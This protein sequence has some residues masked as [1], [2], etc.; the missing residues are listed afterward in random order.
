MTDVVE[1]LVVKGDVSDINA[2]LDEMEKK[3]TSSFQHG[4]KEAKKS[5][6]SMAASMFKG[7]TAATLL[8]KAVNVTKGEFVDSIK[9]AID[10]ERSYIQQKAAIDAM[11][12]G[13]G[14]Y[15]DV[16]KSQAE[17]MKERTG[18]DDD[19]I[20]SIQ[21]MAITYGKTMSQMEGYTR[22]TIM[23]SNATGGR[24]GLTEAMLALVKTE[25]EGALNR[26]LKGIPSLE[27]LTK[28]QLL[29]GEAIGAINN[30]LK[31]FETSQKQGAIG[32]INEM[33]QAWD[34]L[35]K[36]IG[37]V[38]IHSDMVLGS[39]R[40]VTNEI[41]SIQA[42][43][44]GQF[45]HQVLD[46]GLGGNFMH[47]ITGTQTFR[48]EVGAQRAAAALAEKERIDALNAAALRAEQTTPQS[49]PLAAGMAAT[50]L[51]K[52][53]KERMAAE[54]K[55]EE[56][57]ADR[58][59]TYKEDMS[60]D[61][62]KSTLAGSRYNIEEFGKEEDEL[63]DAGERRANIILSLDERI[64][65]GKEEIAQ[66]NAERLEK[67][68]EESMRRI[69]MASEIMGGLTADVLSNLVTGSEQ[70]YKKILA[71]FLKSTGQQLIAMGTKDLFAG[72]ARALWSW[73][74]DPTSEGLIGVGSMEIAA[75]TAM[76]AGGAAWMGKGGGSSG[77]S[78]GGGSSGGGGYG[79]S[80]GTMSDMGSRSSGGDSRTVTIV[81]DGN[82]PP[83]EVGRWAQAGIDRATR[84]GLL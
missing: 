38:V 6:E 71:L 80:R 48:Q 47:L 82:M 34:D 4:D 32:R 26:S 11:L 70:S 18:V 13:M 27:K 72:T 24:V 35:K 21:T 36:S 7:V 49:S 53:K 59:K 57:Y 69:T 55:N 63:K 62:V 68:S 3:L 79:S 28:A 45:A 40:M 8:A 9:Q 83:S 31:E 43:S 56:F 64:A 60:G 46:E 15:A 84:E 50:F 2:K 33:T 54:K 14:K 23:L 41:K 67:I 42:L 22:A 76:A 20:R 81:I 19:A 37:D 44:F 75:G 5:G 58:W 61:R 29:A 17:A 51:D 39:M 16:L 52:S 1:K 66:S 78:S 74:L 65:K 25:E 77:G 12:P 30:N 73:G 10:M